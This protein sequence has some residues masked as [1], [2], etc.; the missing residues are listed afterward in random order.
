M[1]SSHYASFARQDFGLRAAVLMVWLCFCCG[2]VNLGAA[3]VPSVA[4]T[5]R[6]FRLA[7]SSNM[8]TDVNENDARAAMKVWIMTVARERGIPVDPDPHICQTV[9]EL[10]QFSRSNEVDGYGLITTEYARLSKE[11]EF[12]RVAAASNGGSCKEDYVL[13]VRQDSGLERI[14]QLQGRSLNVL[15][16][17]RMSLALIWL[18]TILLQERQEHAARFF[19]RITPFNK[20]SR[21]ALPVFFRQADACLLTRRSFKVMGELNPQ[22]GQQ[23]R[24]V[25]SSPEIVPSIFVFRKDFVSP[26]RA[27]IL[28]EMARMSETPAGQQIL[29]LTQSERIEEHPV[30]CLDSTLALL[31][32]HAKLFATTN[33]VQSNRPGATTPSLP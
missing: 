18:D 25:A 15:Q 22:V 1:S 17:P 20:A 16:N 19:K 11:M 8:F 7:I 30:S 23:M 2:S 26:F 21:V 27:Q 14:E 24:I 10:V 28:A 31:A 33:L 9:E 32:T 13:L 4:A 29:V 6:P 12:D 5:N 3:N